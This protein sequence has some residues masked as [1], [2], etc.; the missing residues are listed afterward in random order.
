MSQPVSNI[1]IWLVHAQKRKPAHVHG[2]NQRRLL[3]LNHR[4][5]HQIFHTS[6]HSIKMV[7]STERPQMPCPPRPPTRASVQFMSTIDETSL[8]I[9]SRIHG[10][11][12]MDSRGEMAGK[13]DDG[14]GH[15]PTGDH[16]PSPSPNVAGH[17]GDLPR[18]ERT[19][20]PPP[21]TDSNVLR[22]LSRP[23]LFG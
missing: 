7:M 21:S 6:V 11:S 8:N 20:H 16:T 17:R 14:D 22:S 10:F 1:A 4:G 9:D 13:P 12:D 2:D 18:V 19:S 15:I 23:L 5:Q 3:T